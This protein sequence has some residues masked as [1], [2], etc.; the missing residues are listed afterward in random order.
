VVSQTE[1]S[2]FRRTKVTLTEEEDCYTSSSDVNDDDDDT[3]DKYDDQELL[4]EFQKL[5]SKHMKL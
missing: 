3:D 4:L 2:D 5:I 1:T